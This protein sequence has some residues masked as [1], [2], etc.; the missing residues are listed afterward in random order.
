MSLLG[1]LRFYPTSLALRAQLLGAR[2]L[3]TGAHRWQALDR[4]GVPGHGTDLMRVDFPP[5]CEAAPRWGHGRAAHPGLERILS[6][7][8][9][10][11]IETLRACLVTA[12][13]RA[14]WPA[15]EDPA[16][17]ELPWRENIF[18]TAFDQAALYGMLRHFKPERYLE[19]G[20]GMS[21]R[22]A[23]QARRAGVFPME[24]ISVDP[25]PRVDVSRLCDAPHRTRLEDMIER[26][27]ALATPRTVVYFDGTHRSFPGSDVTLFFL[28]VLPRLP[29][30]TLVH[31]HDI[32]LPADYPARELPRF[33]SEQYLLA[34]W[35]LG[36]GQGLKVLL[37]CARLA[38]MPHTRAI[39]QEALGDTRVEGSSFWLRK[40]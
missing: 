22:I 3:L 31:I 30:G 36:G 20:S 10:D 6:A 26:F 29:A 40:I 13:D 35:L 11:Q 28:E 5:P 37:P 16:R 32:Y 15:Q 38:A 19:V 9:A 39:A 24:I 2:R 21:T 33:W 34:A 18:Q 4:L 17:P 23:W 27:V 12:D 1:K 14:G 25:L 8:E 7:N